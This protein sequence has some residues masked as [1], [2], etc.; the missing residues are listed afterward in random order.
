MPRHAVSPG[1]IAAYGIGGPH[2]W[3]LLVVEQDGTWAIGVISSSEELGVAI[4]V[5]RA[6]I[7]RLQDTASTISPKR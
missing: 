3:G 4:G 5:Q 7:V 1:V 6:D 2:G